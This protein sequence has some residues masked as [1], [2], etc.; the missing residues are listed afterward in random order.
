M[1]HETCILFPE[2]FHPHHPIRK[3]PL[4]EG[5]NCHLFHT[6]IGAIAALSR[7]MTQRLKLWAGSF[8][9]TQVDLNLAD[10]N[11]RQMQHTNRRRVVCFRQP[12]GLAVE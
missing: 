10:N 8:K 5:L 12:T 6:Q 9:S 3:S 11:D 7:T 1:T 4:E 2:F